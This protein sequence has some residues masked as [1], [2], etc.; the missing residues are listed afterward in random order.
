MELEKLQA[1]FSE[2]T[3]SQ[4]ASHAPDVITLPCNQGFF[5]I[6][7]ATLTKK[8]R[9]LLE[10]FVPQEERNVARTAHPW[11]GVLFGDDL[12]PKKTTVRVIQ[13][14]LH[15]TTD[16]MRQEWVNE[17]HSMF[18]HLMDSFF[19]TENQL[20]MIEEKNKTNYTVEEIFGLFQSLD[21]DF[22]IYTQVFVGRF[23]EE[24]DSLKASIREEQQLFID[25]RTK[26]SRQKNY[27]FSA[28]V[29]E[30][31]MY[32]RMRESALMQTIYQEYFADSEIKEILFTL[33]EC[34]GNISST[35]KQLFLHRNTVL[36]RI[37]KF[38]ECTQFD[39]K[40]MDDL[41]FCYLLVKVFA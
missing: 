37:D 7:K 23:H 4:V 39:L 27:S 16:F 33:W 41:V 31:F 32:E 3:F 36:Y 26:N 20:V 21:I 12:A 25:Q 11:Y 24:M 6:K 22:D 14:Y 8:E 5:H 17:I 18:S 2:G 40:K 13:I 30:T 19:L 34:Q 38:Q 28:A 9:Q 1:L 10:L 29:L 15:Q 35:A